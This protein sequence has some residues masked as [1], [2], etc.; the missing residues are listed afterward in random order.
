LITSDFARDGSLKY[1]SMLFPQYFN[2]K[3][4]NDKIPLLG[5]KKHKGEVKK[6]KTKTNPLSF[7]YFNIMGSLKF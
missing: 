3:A 4:G 7:H 2:G 5:E 6:E 1:F